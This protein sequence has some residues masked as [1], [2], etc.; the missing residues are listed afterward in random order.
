[1][2]TWSDSTT[3]KRQKN[4]YR[5]GCADESRG[6]APRAFVG[7]TES[8]LAKRRAESPTKPPEAGPHVRSCGR[9]EW[10]T[11]PLCRLPGFITG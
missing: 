6:A 7:G 5:M 2:R 3:E 4:Q 1:M 10:A 8:E 9:G 11:P